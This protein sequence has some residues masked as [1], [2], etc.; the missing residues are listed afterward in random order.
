MIDDDLDGQ[1]AEIA[2]LV[3]FARPELA[4]PLAPERLRAIKG[5][6]GQVQ[7]LCVAD[8]SEVVILMGGALL[9]LLHQYTSAA[10]TYFLPDEPDGP[11]PSSRWPAAREALAVSLDWVESASAAPRFPAP[12]LTPRQAHAAE[13]FAHYAYRFALCRQLAHVVAEHIQRPQGDPRTVVILRASPEQEEEADGLAVHLQAST[14][15]D[16]VHLST[17]LSCSVY[18]LTLM[19][20][21]Q[22]GSETFERRTLTCIASASLVHPDAEQGLQV[23]HDD[24][25]RIVASVQETRRRERAEVRAAVA[26]AT[27]DT[28]LEPYLRRSPSGV[29]DA[30][31]DAEDTTLL[32]QLPDELA[33]AVRI[34]R[35]GS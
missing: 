4:A 17:A 1:V 2:D 15:P 35:A 34:S 29:L 13:V 3:P 8:R 7:N 21:L 23:I 20:A 33:H 14:L 6:P 28:A 22:P 32:G 11:R 9:A 5:T 25:Q 31:R 10:A 12:D 24:L 26:A 30:L 18:F 16:P 27:A 19:A